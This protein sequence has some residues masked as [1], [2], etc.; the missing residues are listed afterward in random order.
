MNRLE[1]NIKYANLSEFR[2]IRTVNGI[3]SKQQLQYEK[4]ELF[5]HATRHLLDDMV[6]TKQ[7]YPENETSRVDFDI[8]VVVMKKSD[9]QKLKDII[10]E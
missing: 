7:H 4:Y 1:E 6:K 10:Y 3:P 2:T 5:G 8:D 9:Y